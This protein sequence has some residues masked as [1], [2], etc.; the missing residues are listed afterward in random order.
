MKTLLTGFTGN[1]GPAIAD[2]LAGHQVSALVR[3]P[4]RAPRLPD[5]ELV[6]GSLEELPRGHAHAVEAIVHAAASTAFHAPLDELRRINV[7]GTRR[8]LSFAHR[9]PRLE[10][11]VYLSTIC[12]GGKQSGLLAEAPI[13]DR[14]KFVNAY[15]QSKWEAEQVV[16][17]SGLPVE[18]VRVAIVAGS[19]SDGAVRRPGALHHTVRWLQRGL[20]PMMPG[21]AG[22]PVDLVSTEFVGGVIAALLGEPLH[23]GRIVHAAAGA[24]APT[25]RQLLDH[26]GA[27]FSEQ[28]RGWATGAI[29]LPDIVDAG[30]YALFEQSVARSG[31]VLFRRVCAD[32]QCFLPMLLHPRTC[33]TSL[34]ATFPPPDWRL[35]CQRVLAWLIAT[36]WGRAPH[37]AYAHA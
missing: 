16:L 3:D 32:A 27:L 36:D 20:I 28:H 1:L 29:V 18:I 14:P 30:T 23:A 12:A 26:F 13:L 19:A 8:L 25:L 10:R 37:P 4:A 31:D 24:H 2:A 17:A 7:E 9:C 6:A 34:A 15:E 22:T 33:A 5:V 11:F 21:R 35:L